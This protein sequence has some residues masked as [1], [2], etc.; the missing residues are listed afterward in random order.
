D[1]IPF[2][3]QKWN[4]LSS[5]NVAL[6][7]W[8][9]DLVERQLLSYMARLNYNFSNKYLLT[10]SGRYDGASQLADGNKWSFFPSAALGWSL[11]KENFLADTDWIDQLKLRV[12]VGVTGNS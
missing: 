3:S 8:G 4:A 11:D 7:D 2:P 10:V 5:E 1:N 9:S 6:A 12:G